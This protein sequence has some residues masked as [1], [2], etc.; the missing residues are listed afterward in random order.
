MHNG[1]T[2]KKY[3]LVYFKGK[4]NETKKRKST[5]PKGNKSY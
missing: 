3:K 5:K 2:Q 1:R 4:D